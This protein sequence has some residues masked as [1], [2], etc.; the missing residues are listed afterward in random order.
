MDKNQELNNKE[1]FKVVEK[2]RLKEKLTNSKEK[3]LVMTQTN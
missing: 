1:E 3:S 2:M